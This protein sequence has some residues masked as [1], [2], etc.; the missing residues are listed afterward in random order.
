[1]SDF[2]AAADLT[3]SGRTCGAAGSLSATLSGSFTP[4]TDGRT[5][6][7]AKIPCPVSVMM[8][9]SQSLPA[10]G[11][12]PLATRLI[13]YGAAAEASLGITTATASPSPSVYFAFSPS[14]SYEIHIGIS[15]LTNCAYGVV[16]ST[17]STLPDCCSL[18]KYSK[19]GCR[20]LMSPPLPKFARAHPPDRPRSSADRGRRCCSC[21]P[22]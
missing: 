20:L 2:F 9:L 7:W 12:G 16:P 11:L 8:K 4:G 1:M 3:S 5:N 19:P 10:S 18:R 21:I 6:P 13:A 17:R 15:P 22:A 14:F